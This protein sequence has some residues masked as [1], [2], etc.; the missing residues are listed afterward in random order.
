VIILAAA[1]MLMNLIAD[2]AVA[3]VDPRI[4]LH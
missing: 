3:M 1:I 4:R 2:L